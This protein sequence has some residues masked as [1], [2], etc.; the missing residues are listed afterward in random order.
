M[1]QVLQNISNGETILADI[2]RPL[3]KK[4]NVLVRTTSS[5]VSVGTERMLVDFGKAGWIEK[6]RSQPDKVK[7]VLDKVRTDGLAPTVEAIRSKLEQPLPLGYCNVG[8]V[9][10]GS[11]TGF[12][13]G[14]RVVS[15]GNHAEIVRVPKN[16]VAKIP[17]DV[18]DESASFVVIGAIALQGIRL[19]KPTLGE[20]VV[21]TGLG[22]IGLMAVQLLKANGCRVMGIDFD[23]KKCELA[24]KFGAE[25]VDLSKGEDALA[26]A[27]NF[28]RN[29]GVD[30]VLITASAKDNSIVHQAAE[31]SRKRGRIVLVGVVGLELSRADFYEKEL[32]FQVSCSYGPGRYDKNFEENGNDYPL[33]FVRWT[34]TRN[35]EAI[36]DLMSSGILDVKALITHRFVF[37]DAVNAY[38][39]LNDKSA[40]G[41]LL[42][43]A[44]DDSNNKMSQTITLTNNAQQTGDASCIFLGAGNYS[45]RV[46][47]PAFK[48]AGATLHTVVTSSGINS[49]HHGLKNQFKLASTDFAESLL[50]EA[51]TVVIGTQHNLHAE[52]CLTAIKANKHVFVEKPLALS[53]EEVETI[54][55][56]IKTSKIGTKLMVGFNRRFSPHIQKIKSL[57]SVKPMPKT[58]IFTMNAGAIPKEHWTQD[59]E[60]GGGRIIGEACHY[61]DLMRHLTDSPIKKFSA[62]RMGDSDSVDICE[63]KAI[64]SLVFEDGS[65]GSIH[66]FAN[67]G[68]SFPK[69]RI[70]IFCDEGVLQLDNFKKL[71]GFNWDGFSSFKTRSQNKG[72]SECISAF[73]DTVK[74][75]KEAPIPLEEI[76]EVAK[77]SIEIAD[78][79]R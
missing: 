59:R 76:F 10:E 75:S 46:L 4:G 56:A 17:D 42:Q 78:S 16:L 68:K 26:K 22:L 28:S 69:E 53:I 63:D 37:N 19:I 24:S 72:Q 11:D 15:N 32:S 38:A 7:M 35:F 57:L 51:D 41:I 60:L 73:V 2:P 25:T 43:Y 71:S 40:L 50:T 65:I 23:S 54:E 14:Q 79:L 49:Y 39:V 66:Y 21:V 70:E 12:S 61:I 48:S 20:C 30:A 44:D 52:Q 29:K 62:I 5:L 58:F 34:E 67:G 27:K 33:P 74:N 47:M 36:L 55:E 77:V 3:S 1:K 13:K 18:D 8:L 45:S 9:E 31:M 6:A 64:I